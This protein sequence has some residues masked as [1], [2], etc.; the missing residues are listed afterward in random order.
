M[1]GVGRFP[2][3]NWMGVCCHMYEG[4]CDRGLERSVLPPSGRGMERSV[5]TN[6]SELA[7]IKVWNYC[8]KFHKK[9]IFL[10]CQSK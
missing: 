10:K 7:N 3:V 9:V 2:G 4:S 6:I 5:R 8:N 1:T